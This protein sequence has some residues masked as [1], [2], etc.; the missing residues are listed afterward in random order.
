LPKVLSL[1]DIVYSEPLIRVLTAADAMAQAKGGLACL[2]YL[3]EA[4]TQEDEGSAVDLL[5]DVG[6]TSD[7]LHGT[8]VAS[9]GGTEVTVVDFTTLKQLRTWVQKNGQGVKVF[10]FR[11]KYAPL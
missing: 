1:D 10:G 6:M 9:L 8:M 7:D 4:L 2:Q 3:L 11:L 5:H